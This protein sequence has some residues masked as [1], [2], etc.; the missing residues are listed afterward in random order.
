MCCAPRA[1]VA[2]ASAVLPPLFSR[3]AVLLQPRES[4]FF[5]RTRARPRISP[6]F[7][8]G[9]WPPPAGRSLGNSLYCFRFCAALSG[10]AVQR[11]PRVRTTPRPPPARPAG[12][13][14]P[15]SLTERPQ[16]THTTQAH[17]A[18]HTLTRIRFRFF[19]CSKLKIRMTIT[20]KKVTQA[21]SMRALGAKS[22]EFVLCWRGRERAT[23]ALVQTHTKA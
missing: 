13:P 3:G 10:R 14:T 2:T 19:V 17:T 15:F 7:N 21:S 4:F 12:P 20:F 11:F 6:F 18:T 8:N 16:S 1:P 9:G 23:Y 22:G 5:R